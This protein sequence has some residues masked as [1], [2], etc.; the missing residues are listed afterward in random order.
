M[1]AVQPVA[2]VPPGHPSPAARRDDPLLECLQILTR[3]HGHPLSTPALLGSLPL[4]TN[5][6]T[7]SLLVRAAER[8]GY[9]ARVLKRPLRRISNLVLPAVLLLEGDEACVLTAMPRGR[10]ARVILLQSGDSEKTVKKRDLERQS[11]G[12]CIFAQPIPR[13]DERLREEVPA[14]GR[15]WLLGTLWRFRGYYFE[16]ALAAMLIN[17]LGLA[18]ALFIMNVYDRVVPNQA[19]DTLIVLAVGVA[20]AVG[21]EFLARNIRGYFLDVAARKADVLLGSTVFAHALGLRMQ[22]RPPSAGAFASQLREYETLRDFLTSATLTAFSDLPFVLFFVWVIYLIGGPL[23]ILPLSAVPLV[24]LVGLLAQIPLSMLMG[25]H[26]RE[27]NLKHGLL[28]ESVEGMETLKTLC[29]EGAMQGRWEDYTALTGQTGSRVRM[30]STG[31]VSFTTTVVQ[32]VTIGIVVWGVHLV[33]AGT[34]SVG[35]LIACVILNGRGLAPLSQ[36]ASLLARYQHARMAYFILDGLMRRPGER[37]AGKNFLHRERIEGAVEFNQVTFRYPEQPLPVFKDLSL[38]I[39]PGE[40]VAVLGRVGTGKST[41]LK[42]LLALYAPDQGVVSLDGADVA[43]FD[44]ADLRRSIGYVSQD[45]RL[46][47]GTLRDNIALGDPTADDTAVLEAARISGLEAMVADHPQGFDMIVPE[48]GEGLSGGQ[49]QAIG[50]ARALLKAP[51]LLLMD[52]ATASMDHNTEQAFLRN[53]KRFAKGRTLVVVTHKPTM[54]AVAE[55]VVVLDAGRVAADGPRDEILAALS[56]APSPPVV[57]AG[58]VSQ[59]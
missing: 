56:Q 23:Y 3:L 22:D 2:P 59:G 52:E 5:A 34:L 14:P 24:L 46:F 37:T 31:V 29:A 53:L 7:P 38:R 15:M 54:V 47:Y 45:V 50:I 8:N 20:M 55:R 35:G 6:M 27:S 4:D 58:G 16:A 17:V 1:A 57:N 51:P 9:T 18:T 26:V 41:L 42:L 11:T 12:Y 43:Q 49:R 32:V 44:P 25:R 28:V 36:V 33:G 10:S 39:R 21:F 40:H 19:V 30:I 48:R 13:S